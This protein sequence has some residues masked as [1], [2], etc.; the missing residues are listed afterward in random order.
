MHR[1]L[2]VAAALAAATLAACVGD[3]AATAAAAARFADFQ[4]ALLRGDE[5]ACRDLLTIESGAALAE[6]P[7]AEVRARQPLRILG[8]E[9]RERD[10]RV[11]VEDPNAGGA[12]SE[13]VVVREYGKLVV[14]L[15]A[16]A[17]LHAE[18]ATAVEA[19]DQRSEFVPRELTPRDHE[20]IR[21]QE[22]SE[23]PR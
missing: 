17:G 19:A 5:S 20:R 11:Q 3:A 16:S 1:I 14:D 2:T 7:W 23:P 4:A 6:I 9:R 13:F 21:R 8:A 18:P 15:V 22:L 10:F 12:H